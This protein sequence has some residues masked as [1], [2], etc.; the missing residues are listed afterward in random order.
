MLC[1]NIKL[2]TIFRTY[3]DESVRDRSQSLCAPPTTTRAPPHKD[4]GALRVLQRRASSVIDIHSCQTQRNAPLLVAQF[5]LRERKQKKKENENVAET[6]FDLGF[7]NNEH[8]ALPAPT[9][10][11]LLSDTY[12]TGRRPVTHAGTL[13]G[14]ID[15]QRFPC[16]AT[17]RR[18]H[19]KDFIDASGSR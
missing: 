17:R 15:K 19:L 3:R 4:I 6:K 9:G 7:N 12:T 14:Q 11:S 8:G 10:K 1:F 5:K 16:L 2:A 18:R 13:E